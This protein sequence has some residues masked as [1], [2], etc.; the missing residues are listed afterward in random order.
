M[1]D[2]ERRSAPPAPDRPKFL[3]R[4]LPSAPPD[5]VPARMINELI[6]CERLAYLEW[7]QG[8][9]QD[10]V[11]TVDGRIVHR[12]ADARGGRMPDDDDEPA[13]EPPPFT[14]RSVMLASERL[15][16]IAKIDVVEGANGEV[17]PVEYKRGAAPGVPGGAYLPERAQ[18]CAHVLLL[19]EHG[20]R[21]PRGEIYFAGD[22]Q[23]V[24]IE[25]DDWLID[26]TL[27][28]VRRLRELTAT[29]EIPPPLEDSPK[30]R[31]CSLAGV[32]LPDEVALLRAL[33]GGPID[34][35]RNEPKQMS[36][37]FAPDLVGPM[38]ADPWGL[39]A[40][41]P[42]ERA[43]PAREVRRLLPPR[44]EG[45][46]LYVQTQGAR[47]SVDG[48]CLRVEGV[49]G[50]APVV[51]R[52]AHTSH[53]ALFGNVQIT[54]QAIGALL[55]RDIPIVFLS[56]SG[57]YRG[58]TIAHGSKNIE[59]RVAQHR[60]ADRPD[61]ATALARTFVAAK[62]RNQRTMLRRNHASA[63]PV[64]LNELEGLAKKAERAES[65]A[66]LLGLEGTAARYYFGAFTGMLKGVAADAFDLDG[67]NRRPPRDPINA[68][69]SLAYALLTK[70]CVLAV[71][72]VGMDPLLG[73]L[74]QPRYGR[75]ALALDLMEEMRPILADSV[76]ITAV[77]TQVIGDGDFV[78]AR[79]GCALTDAGRRRF[80]E[81][82]ERRMD[83][84]VTHPLFGYRISYRRVL[85]VQARLL[86][87]V[88]LGE[89]PSYPA[90]R[91]R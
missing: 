84:L 61:L 55:D 71:G 50:A 58:R 73:F 52:L 82:Y 63:D 34:L 12:R 60:T 17:V 6:Y 18:V 83:Q 30:C 38:Q 65:V 25:V 7:A 40:T 48:E 56:Q 42:S 1:T 26:E 68:M 36:F 8:E 4:P 39:D 75:P 69:L 59:L 23:R 80:I 62:I 5:L 88:L 3:R 19:R 46:P 29:G 66:S 28:A 32:C 31:G 24:P 53:V 10:N 27:G 79:T 15:G 44:D 16:I 70:D 21:C 72:A 87:R 13:D 47:V 57:W 78:H 41:D 20:Y 37:E 76:V 49:A 64:V 89:V 77:N 45:M 43:A 54:T 51:A 9:F 81:A 74:H 90:F 91:T 11:Y 86:S 22:R 85:E 67:R 14:A 33:E 35:E 2:P